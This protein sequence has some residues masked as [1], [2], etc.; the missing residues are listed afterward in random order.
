MMD[1]VRT[2]FGNERFRMIFAT[3]IVLMVTVVLGLACGFLM[4]SEYWT[5]A[6][7]VVGVGL[8]IL[9]CLINPLDGLLLWMMLAPFSR[10]IYLDIRLP[11]GIPDLS[12]SRLTIAFLLITLSAQWA[13]GRRHLKPFLR[14]DYFMGL[15]ILGVLP[16]IFISW[17]PLDLAGRMFFDHFLTPMAA[18]FIVKNLVT[19]ERDMQRVVNVFMIIGVYLALL[20]FHE[21]VTG[22][23]LFW[24]P[25]RA[26]TYSRSLQKL[27]SLLGNPLFLA[28][29][30]GMA[31]PFV[32]HRFLKE[33]LAPIKALYL[34]LGGTLA[35]CIYLCYNR[36]AYLGLA[37]GL[38]V[39]MVLSS[40][41]R[42]LFIPLLLVL[43][44]LVVIYWGEIALS[45]VVRERITNV[46]SVDFRALVWQIGLK[47]FADS[48]IVGVGYENFD[49]YFTRYHYW[50]PESPVPPSPHNTYLLILA[51]TGLVGFVPWI[52]VFLSLLYAL[53]GIWLRARRDPHNDV[54][55]LV[56][57]MAAL[58]C[59]LV[60]AAT[61]DIIY[62]TLTNL[63]FYTL[64]GAML[65]YWS[66]PHAQQQPAAVEPSLSAQL[67]AAE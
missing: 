66:W 40:N 47:M 59:F 7:T 54:D 29:G 67:K 32:V 14:T 60:A 27:V 36:G 65:G 8:V 15:F 10:F 2:A 44:I 20:V 4:K 51:T 57:G 56:A 49:A 13:V 12:L 22:E 35:L 24:T 41:F 9:V 6:I 34:I 53:F 43:G 17:K 52:F 3:A 38:M 39:M 61:A 37:M 62:D 23:P 64:A 5:T 21:V 46:R 45:P 26:T 28:T 1:D 50:P 18:Y 55:F 30:M 19:T 11:G 42:R 48:P 16:A 33:R 25:G 58:V 63:M 31:W